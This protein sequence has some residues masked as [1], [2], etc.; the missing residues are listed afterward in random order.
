V[1]IKGSHSRR[2]VLTKCQS[3][4]VTLFGVCF[5]VCSRWF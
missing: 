4:V 1:S 5:A 2:C 3:K